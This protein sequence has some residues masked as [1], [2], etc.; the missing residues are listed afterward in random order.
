MAIN[1]DNVYKTVLL[2]LNQEQR[3]YITPDELNKTATQ[4]QLDIFKK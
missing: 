4:V 2:V 1:V 3:G